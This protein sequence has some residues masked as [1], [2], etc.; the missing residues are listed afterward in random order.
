MSPVIYRVDACDRLVAVNDEWRRFALANGGAPIA[1]DWMGCSLWDC[2]AGGTIR[3]FY[4]RLLMKVRAGQAVQVDFHCDAP[5]RRRQMR[6]TMTPVPDGGV[7]FTSELLS[8]QERAP[9]ELP[10][11]RL[12]RSCAWC[13]RIWSLG[14]WLEIEAAVSDL[15]LF[16]GAAPLPPVTHGLCPDCERRLSD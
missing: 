14:G 10:P 3:F 16:D 6:L 15:R 1:D 4:R 7:A 2:I 9:V 11:G 13:A 12:L 5:T 8:E